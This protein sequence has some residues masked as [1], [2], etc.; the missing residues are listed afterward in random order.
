MP[1]FNPE[2]EAPAQSYMVHGE[3]LSCEMRH[4][5]FD[6]KENERG[7]FLLIKETPTGGKRGRPT[8]IFVSEAG[9]LDFIEVLNRFKPYLQS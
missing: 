5:H 2:G 1:I 4:Y 3:Q 6:L 9:L 7:R 8:K